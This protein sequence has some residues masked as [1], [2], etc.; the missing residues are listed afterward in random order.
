MIYLIFL[1]TAIIGLYFA[2]D[3]IGLVWFSVRIWF[4]RLCFH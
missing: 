4:R 2:A 3:N 1:E